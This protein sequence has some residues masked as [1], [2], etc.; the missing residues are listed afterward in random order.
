MLTKKPMDGWQYIDT[1][2][3]VMRWT[4][5][6]WI[7]D[8]PVGDAEYMDLSRPCSLWREGEWV[9]DYPNGR[10]AM[11]EAFVLEQD[12]GDRCTIVCTLPDGHDGPCVRPDDGKLRG[13]RRRDRRPK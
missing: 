13:L 1:G 11:K 6:D 9:G 10:K 7:L 4:K 3:G 5:D 8:A 12:L 2:K